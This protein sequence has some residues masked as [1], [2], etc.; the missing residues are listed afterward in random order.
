VPSPN[1]LPIWYSEENFRRS[2]AQFFASVEKIEY[3]EVVGRTRVL[4]SAKN[5]LSRADLGNLDGFEILNL[6]ALW[7]PSRLGC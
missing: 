3:P 7:G 4:F 5:R 2:L 1:P 6:A